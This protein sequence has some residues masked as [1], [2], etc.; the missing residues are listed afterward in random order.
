MLALVTPLLLF[1]VSCEGKNDDK[2][3]WEW[4]NDEVENSDKPRILW[5]D[6]AANFKD[7]ANSKENIFRDL[8][9][10]K[11][12]GFTG[13][14]VDVRPTSGDVLFQTDVVDQ[15]EWLGAWLSKGY[16]KVERTA[17]W[18]YLEAFIDAGRQ[19]DLKI[20]AG[21]NTFVGGNTTNLGSE[22]VLFRDSEKEKW[23][24]QL[25]TENGIKSTLEVGGSGAK[26]FNP[27]REDVQN[28][29]CNFLE[30]L[31]AYDGLE[32]IILDRG[33][34][35]GLDSDFSSYTKSK[36]EEF[37][38]YSIQNFPEDVMKPGTTAGNFPSPTPTYFKEWLEFRVKVMHDFFEKAAFK[39]NSVNPELKFGVYVG[40]WY[41]TYY[42]V[43]VNW[44]SPDY[45]TASDYLSWATSDYKNYGY[46]DI[47]DIILIGAYAAPARVYGTSEWTVQGFCSKA[48]DKIK[49]DA[50]VIGG[51]DIGNGEWAT[52]GDEVTNEAIIQSVDAVMDVCDGYFLFDMIHLKNKNQWNYVKEGIDNL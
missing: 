48:C 8:Q 33:R 42:E 16:A 37:L 26:F 52:A 36:F 38:G 29:I 45:N 22:G 39:V 1:T 32:G 15:V 11:D 47:M 30:D 23:A 31:A 50:T 27:V 28:Y 5:I 46:A 18:D 40:G 51:P 41:S 44:A 7:F 9:L 13:V 4:D 6:A 12:A 49:G 19:L 3:E 34:F 17:A 21:I 10:A 25:L 2:P 20:Y 14:V 43:G 35:A 24:T